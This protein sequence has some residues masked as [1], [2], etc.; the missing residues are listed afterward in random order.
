MENYTLLRNLRHKKRDPP[1]RLF[2]NFF[3]LYLIKRFAS[4]S[5]ILRSSKQSLSLCL[6]LE[7]KRG[8]RE[9]LRLS[10]HGYALFT[11]NIHPG[12]IPRDME[13]VKQR[14]IGN[15]KWRGAKR[16]R[17]TSYS[18]HDRE[19]RRATVRFP[20]PPRL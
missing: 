20:R 4:S 6:S 9:F 8:K 7:K 14:S 16:E 11:P 12:C 13:T 17:R 3:V 18:R 15:G 10:E 19:I 2:I 5:V 1:P